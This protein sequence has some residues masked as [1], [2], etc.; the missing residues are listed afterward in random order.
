MKLTDLAH[1]L[2]PLLEPVVTRLERLPPGILVLAALGGS[3][4]I[5][6]VF[7]VIPD[8]LQILVGY[9]LV[10]IVLQWGWVGVCIWAWRRGR[11]ARKL[12]A[13]PKPGLTPTFEAA[14][15]ALHLPTASG[16]LVLNNPFRGLLITGGAG[17]GKSYS[18]I[19]PIIAQAVQKDFAGLV[20]D[21]KFPT[22]AR[23]VADCLHASERLPAYYI[24]FVDLTRSHRVN[25]LH[26]DLFPSVSHAKQ[27]SKLLVHNLTA[28]K[29]ADSDFWLQ[30]AINLIAS[31]MWFLRVKHPAYCTLPHALN[32]LFHE[33]AEFVPALRS[34]PQAGD[35]VAG[36][37]SAVKGDAKAQISGVMGSTQNAISEINTPEICYVLSGHDFALDVND[38]NDPKWL[39]L[40]NDSSL[41]KVYSP[42]LALI[43]QVATDRMNREGKAPSVVVLDEAPTLF[44]PEFSKLP[45][46]CSTLR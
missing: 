26:P 11:A 34:D 28:A 44:L 32:L 23:H 37:A 22:L 9:G 10:S 29:N 46:T 12:A 20:Y 3:G 19:E 35:L 40:G 43:V 17:A 14:P 33:P 16:E 5:S 41:S 13:E 2:R 25:P 30:S 39:V 7:W 18:L 38:P 8:F 21:F 1:G 27:L 15:L 24:N 42:V 36:L 45:S 6:L 31:A 4:A